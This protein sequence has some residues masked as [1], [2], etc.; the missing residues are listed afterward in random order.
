[1]VSSSWL[2][3]GS[4]ANVTV[5]REAA[6]CTKYLIYSPMDA[7]GIAML[8]WEN[9]VRNEIVHFFILFLRADLFVDKLSFWFRL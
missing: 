8:F 2:F 5:V 4:C 7:S 6:K 3:S 9:T 1:M